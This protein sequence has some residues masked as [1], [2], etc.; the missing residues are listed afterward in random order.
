MILVSEGELT[1]ANNTSFQVKERD[2]ILRRGCIVYFHRLNVSSR[3]SKPSESDFFLFSLIPFKAYMNK[4]P[5]GRHAM[6][7]QSVLKLV[8]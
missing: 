6:I 3:E 2:F 4:F 8:S 1:R 7:K 5:I